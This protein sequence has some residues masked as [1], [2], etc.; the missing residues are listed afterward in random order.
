[1][2]L[3]PF[4]RIASRIL[5]MNSGPTIC[6]IEI[7]DSVSSTQTSRGNCLSKDGKGIGLFRRCKRQFAE[8]DRTVVALDHD[9]AGVGFVAIERAAGDAGDVLALDNGFAV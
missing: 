6:T 3:R 8:F 5:L 4:F 1:M 7:E 9:G 2:K